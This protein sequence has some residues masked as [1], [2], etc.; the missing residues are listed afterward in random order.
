VR[1]PLNARLLG[2]RRR[3]FMQAGFLVPTWG[4]ILL[5]VSAATSAVKGQRMPE[6][7]TAQHILDRASKAYANFRTYR[8]SGSVKTTFIR[9]DGKWTEKKVFVTAFVRPDRLRFEYKEKRGEDELRYIV[10]RQGKDVRTWW[11]VK[12][13]IEKPVSLGL[14]LAGATGVSGGSAH[15]VPALLLPSEVG[16]RRL[17]DMAGVSRIEDAKLGEADCF[18]VKGNYAGTPI[19]LWIEKKAFLV[20]RIDSQ[21][22]FDDFRTEGTTVYEP[23]V[24]SE[25]TDEMLMFDPPEKG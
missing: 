20:L 14:A 25:I 15:T 2:V 5:V 21:N 9:A 12:P 18:R 8:D 7:P 4:C 11:D 13:G 16:G 19:T 3:A 10:W 24:D 1:S 22:Q 6:A 23:V 17:T